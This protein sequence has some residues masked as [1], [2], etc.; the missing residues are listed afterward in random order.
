MPVVEIISK[1][2]RDCYRCLRTCPVHA[3]TVQQGHAR[4]HAELCLSC[5]H[6][7]R[8]CPRRA[9]RVR[10]A[11]EAVQEMIASGVPVVASVA[12]I[13]SARIRP[14]VVELMPSLMQLGFAGAEATT[15]AL[16]PV[17][18]RYR[19]ISRKA[20]HPI[21]ASGCPSVVALI[22]RHY[23]EALP[24]LAPV[25]SYA[26]AHA[27]MIKA[28]A[29]Q[30]GVPDVKVVHIGPEP[31]IKG[32]L[33][34]AEGPTAL[35]AALT[36]PE[37]RRWIRREMKNGGRKAQVGE[38][39]IDDVG[40]PLEWVRNILPIYGPDQ[41]VDYLKKIPKGIPQGT[42]VEMATCRYGCAIGSPRLLARVREAAAHLYPKNSNLTPGADEDWSGQDLSRDFSDR[43]IERVP[44]TDA[45]MEEILARVGAKSGERAL[46][47]GACGYDTCREMAIAVHHGMAEV[48]MC[49]P[50]MRRQAHRISL[51][52][53]FTANG[54]LLVNHDMRIEF[55]NPAFQR[56]FH[57][58]DRTLR[59]R[60]VKEVLGNDIFQQALQVG[61]MLSVRAQ[62]REH[63]LVYRAQI[64]PIEGEPL[65]A[66]VI[67]DIT[68]ETRASEEYTRVREATLERGQEVITRQMKTAQEIAG[69]LGETAAETKSLLVKLMDLV[70]QEKRE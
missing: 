47:C 31:A 18:T 43:H 36:L 53:H 15:H 50:A 10:P 24:M 20:P 58:E 39:T 42:V 9:I 14:I 56:M 59:N 33:R 12:L 32:E 41:C 70:R 34:H 25:V 44:P 35:D 55:A 54:V 4:V 6:C 51:I 23:P 17:W 60:P 1:T 48:E 7:V 66:A 52:L 29:R 57:C 2:C 19:A 13:E 63:D 30:R 37:V 40:P 16:R 38:V 22:E 68:K 49:M 11:L 61:G 3:I 64:F 69:L 21:I 27:R 45:Q 62:L 28:R 5:G 46:D 65:L 67:V 26:E 8:E